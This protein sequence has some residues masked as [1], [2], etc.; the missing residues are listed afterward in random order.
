MNEE[1]ED[2]ALSHSD[3]CTCPVC[4]RYVYDLAS[5]EDKE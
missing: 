4:E 1:E 5:E 2:E 3:I